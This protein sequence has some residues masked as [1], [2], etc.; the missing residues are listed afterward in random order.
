MEIDYPLCSLCKQLPASKTNS[1]LIPSFMIA[2]VCNYDRS[3]QR[4]KEV[5]VTMTTY[6]DKIY[7]G[8]IPS[9]KY[10]ELFDMNK[11]TEERIDS[12]LKVNTASKD[13]ILCPDCEKNLSV[14][15]ESPY[16]K[17]FS[18]EKQYDKNLSYYF[19]LSIVWLMSISDQFGFRLPFALE[20]E[21]GDSLYKYLEFMRQGEDSSSYLDSCSFRYRL[22]FSPD[23]LKDKNYAGYFGGRFDSKRNILSLTM[24][25]KILCITFN[26]Q[27]IPDDYVYLG[28]ENELRETVIND[29]KND[30][31]YL[32]VNKDRFAEGIHQFVKEA[33]YKRLHNEK[34]LAD[35]LWKQVGLPGGYMPD[36]I[37]NELMRRLYSDDSK[38]GER[39]TPERYVEL[40]NEV[41]TSYGFMPVD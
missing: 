37:Y 10:E 34:E 8:A 1:H 31:Q 28:M 29:G 40:F 25:D 27:P 20:D 32:I 33:A 7:T 23:Y 2:P 21:L 16:S 11:L 18:I 13:Y 15:L 39:K 14:F 24:G 5:M 6:E 9:T 26:D 17:S 3:S 12:E 41:L 30:E 4:G 22:L 19:W 35:A 36:I 38:L